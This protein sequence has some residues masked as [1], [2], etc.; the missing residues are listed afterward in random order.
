MRYRVVIFERYAS[1]RIVEANSPE[2]AKDLAGD[3]EEHYHEYCDTLT[4]DNW[5]VTEESN[6][7]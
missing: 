7:T 5:T 6:P 4:K 2:E 1:H 3:A